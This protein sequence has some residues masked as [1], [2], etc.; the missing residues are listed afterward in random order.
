[1]GLRRRAALL[2]ALL[3]AACTQPLPGKGSPQDLAYCRQLSDLYVRYVGPDPNQSGLAG[4][5]PDVTG[6]E[7]LAQCRAGNAAA[8]I[9]TLERLLLRADFTLPPRP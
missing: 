4:V 8:A 7:A 5:T 3:L 6:G 2:P 9:P 1:M